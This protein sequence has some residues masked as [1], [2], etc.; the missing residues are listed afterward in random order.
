MGI[1]KESG[2]NWAHYTYNPW[3]GCC[4]TSCPSCD[5]CYAEAWAKRCGFDC[6]GVGKNA[7]LFGKKHWNDPVVW[8][9]KAKKLGVRYRVFCG[10]MCDVFQDRDDTVIA[11]NDLWKLV[12]STQHL[13]WMLLTKR[14]LNALKATPVE[15]HN[16]WPVNAWA[17][18]SLSTAGY[19]CQAENLCRI[20][21]TVRFVSCE[22][23]L[24]RIN[25]RPYL[26]ENG[27][28][29][30]IAGGESGP[31]ARPTHP[32]DLRDLRDQCLA[33]GCKFHFKQW[34]EWAGYG[35]APA[36]NGSVSCAVHEWGNLMVSMRIGKRR[37][38]HMLD[39]VEYLPLSAGER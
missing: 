15:W 26:G 14:P 33:A 28:H 17:G 24:S 38:G 11:R 2:I 30:V 19:E 7:R 8:N 35:Q 16:Q 12:E 6:F 3:W 39:G 29:L 31:H 37:S 9:E 25:L 36:A 18:V 10:S 13:D 23:L 20:P 27:I 5:H 4:K 21:A 34:G 22:P 32:N 1:Q